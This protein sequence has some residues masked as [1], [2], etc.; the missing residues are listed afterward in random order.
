LF[1]RLPSPLQVELTRRG[2]PHIDLQATSLELL[3]AL[4]ISAIE[5]L[6]PVVGTND[7]GQILRAWCVAKG[8]RS[9]IFV[10]V[11]DHSRRTRRVLDRAL[12]QHGIAVTVRWARFSQFD[13]DNWWLSRN[14]QRVEIVESQKLFADVLR[15]PF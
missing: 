11:A 4:G 7:E 6:P 1:A 8:I 3:H 13:P 12:A 5:L 15:H 9:I 14:G 10:S 2:L